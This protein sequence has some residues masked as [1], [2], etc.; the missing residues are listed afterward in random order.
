MGVWHIWDLTRRLGGDDFELLI[1]EF[2][3]TEARVRYEV[4]N[5]ILWLLYEAEKKGLGISELRKAVAEWIQEAKEEYIEL[6]LNDSS[7]KYIRSKIERLGK[8]EVPMEV[9]R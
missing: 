8:K 2:A 1:E 4:L 5:Q 9:A 6:V 7:Y 3:R